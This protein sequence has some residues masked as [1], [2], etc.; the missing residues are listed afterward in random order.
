MHASEAH[1]VPDWPLAHLPVPTDSARHCVWLRHAFDT[2]PHAGF[3]MPSLV[4][5]DHG[6]MQ[7]RARNSYTHPTL[8]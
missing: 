6:V 2:L 5:A 3:T 7:V 4:R 8:P 1:T